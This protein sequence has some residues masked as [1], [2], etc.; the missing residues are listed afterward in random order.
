MSVAGSNL[1]Q[2]E[3]A[4]A[5]IADNAVGFGNPRQDSL[6]GQ[7]RFF[8]GAQYLAVEADP[9]DLAHEFGPVLGVADRRGRDDVAPFHLHVSEQKLEALQCSQGLVARPVR[10]AP[11]TIDAG[12]EPGQNLFVEDRRW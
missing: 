10:K 3:A 6:A 1:D 4:A 5:E 8:F 7:P 2:L 11:G 12:A 9:F